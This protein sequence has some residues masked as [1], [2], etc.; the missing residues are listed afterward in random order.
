MHALV[1]L[2]FKYRGGSDKNI[3]D[4][5]LFE[6]GSYLGDRLELINVKKKEVEM[7]IYQEYP[8][9][10]NFINIKNKIEQT[11]RG[12]VEYKLVIDED[13]VPNSLKILNIKSNR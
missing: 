3:Q 11:V 8:D 13:Y 9:E 10:V 1:K 7:W 4:K 6:F 2:K 5:L 12:L